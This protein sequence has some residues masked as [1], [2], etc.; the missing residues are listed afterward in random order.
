MLLDDKRILVTGG[1]GSLGKVLLRRIL[2][3]SSGNPGKI[4]V[5]SRD[6][7]KQHQIRVEYQH[8]RLATDEIIYR[9][10]HDLLEFRIG[11]V[12]D[13]HSISAALRGIDIEIGRAYV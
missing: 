5:F 2:S 10:F 7:S 1:T 4:V 8:R 9:N 6:E 3:G 11:D 13:F 12:R